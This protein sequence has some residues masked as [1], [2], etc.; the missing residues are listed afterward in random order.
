MSSLEEIVEIEDEVYNPDKL[1]SKIY[2]TVKENKKYFQCYDPIF[3]IQAEFIDILVDAIKELEGKT[4][5]ESN[6]EQF[7]DFLLKLNSF[8][9]SNEKKYQDLIECS[10]RSMHFKDWV[11]YSNEFLRDWVN[12]NCF[13]SMRLLGISMK[14]EQEVNIIRELLSSFEKELNT[15]D[16]DTVKVILNQ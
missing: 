5:K 13:F 7:V 4:L 9:L 8:T 11:K 6:D 15:D 10:D 12:L 2:N 1:L 14:R 16:D 3:K